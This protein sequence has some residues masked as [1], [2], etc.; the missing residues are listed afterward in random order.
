[1]HTANMNIE[2]PVRNMRG[3]FLTYVEQNL[4]KLQSRGLWDGI[5]VRPEE[6][7]YRG[8]FWR[9]TCDS[10]ISPAFLFHWIRT[11][12]SSTECAEQMTG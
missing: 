10:A 8:L 3:K 7:V 12:M 11:S 5:N 4:L 1:M 6:R 9:Q 2:S